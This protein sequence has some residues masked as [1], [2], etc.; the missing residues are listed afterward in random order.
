[1]PWRKDETSIN[2]VRCF[3]LACAVLLGFGIGK[4]QEHQIK[5][6]NLLIPKVGSIQI[7]I[8]NGISSH[9]LEKIFESAAFGLTLRA[10]RQYAG[11][12]HEQEDWA[13]LYQN[14]IMYPTLSDDGIDCKR[15]VAYFKPLGP[16]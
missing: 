5:E 16:K 7:A 4:V 12:C 11:Y 10:G 3:S 6:D 2:V 14:F 8:D 15:V 1:M 13:R 9:A